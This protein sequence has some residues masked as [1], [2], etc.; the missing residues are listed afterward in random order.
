MDNKYVVYIDESGIH[1]SIDHSSFVIVY[2]KFANKDILNRQ[3]LEIENKLGIENF[4]WS[5]YSTKSGWNIR[6]RFVKSISKL[7]FT[8]KYTI[9]KNPINTKI[10]LD[11]LLIDISRDNSIHEIYIDGKQLKWV[12]RKIKKSLRDRGMRIGKVKLVDDKSEPVI[13]IADAIANVV[14]IYHD[15]PQK[16]VKDLFTI[17]SKKTKP[18]I[19]K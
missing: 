13:R 18:P 5:D 19:S 8:F 4:H 10:E 1:K 12:E 11:N 14:R 16:L 2:V 9:L 17:L 6:S 15:K 7:D 3:V